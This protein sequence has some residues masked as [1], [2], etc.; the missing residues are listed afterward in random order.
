MHG[1]APNYLTHYLTYQHEYTE[2]FTRATTMNIF[3]IPNYKTNNAKRSF[4]Y[5]GS[6][7]WN[8][9]PDEIKIAPTVNS[10]KFQYRKHVLKL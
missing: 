3:R 9:L 5:C 4:N 2:R 1:N 7:L 6:V 8:S 10:F